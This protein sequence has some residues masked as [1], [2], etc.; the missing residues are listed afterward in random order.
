M[1][2]ITLQPQNLTKVCHAAKSSVQRSFH[3]DSNIKSVKNCSDRIQD[4]QTTAQNVPSIVERLKNEVQKFENQ[5]SNANRYGME[6]LYYCGKFESQYR[7]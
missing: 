1:F 3:L 2:K 4:T 6:V 7:N 5:R